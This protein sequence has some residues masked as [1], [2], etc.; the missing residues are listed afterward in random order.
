MFCIAL[1]SALQ[2]DVLLWL[3]LPAR[4]SIFSITILLQWSTLL[5]RG[6]MEVILSIEWLRRLGQ[7]V[8]QDLL[9]H[10]NATQ[11][12]SKATTQ[13]LAHL[14][15]TV[16]PHRHILQIWHHRATLCSTK[17]KNHSVGENSKPL[18][19]WRELYATPCVVSSKSGKL[20][21]SAIYQRDG[22]SAMTLVGST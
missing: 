2:P 1:S 6:D 21:L 20:P 17:W 7:W 11:Y 18:M 14:A 22:N 5:N 15:H 10:D 16:E 9:L 8:H 12:S 3:M 13:T 19:T 4:A